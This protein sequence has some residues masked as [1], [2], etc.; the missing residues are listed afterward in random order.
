MPL[1]L[2][3]RHAGEYE[4]THQVLLHVLLSEGHLAEELG[5]PRVTAVEW[6]YERSLFDLAVKH[7]GD[8]TTGVEIKT[9]S[10]VKPEQAER[11]RKWASATGRTLLYVLLGNSEFEGVPGDEVANE[12]RVGAAALRDAVLRMADRND[13]SPAVRGLARSYAQWLESHVAERARQLSTPPENWGRLEYAVFYDRVRRA[14]RWEASIYPSNNPGGPVYILNFDDGWTELRD[15]RVSGASFYWEIV[16]GFVFF[17]MGPVPERARSDAAPKVREELRE[18]LVRAAEKHGVEVAPVGRTG[19]YMSLAKSTLDVRRLFAHGDLD[20]K[21]LRE[22]LTRC[23]KV[24][25]AVAREWRAAA[26]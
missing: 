1:D 8:R 26:A 19:E 17:K 22:H 15:R 7:R 4:R 11:Q 25:E 9:W 10:E 12:R 21:K 18:L 2:L 24:Y 6:E 16:D 5:L 13:S 20:E 14:M 3:L 23:R